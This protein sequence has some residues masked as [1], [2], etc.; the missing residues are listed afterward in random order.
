MRE[1]LLTWIGIGNVEAVLFRGDPAAKP[2]RE[3]ALLRGGIVGSQLPVLRP[4]AVALRPGDILVMAT[5]GIAHKFAARSYDP[6][7]PQ[8]LA[9]QILRDYGKGTDD[10]LVLVV[11]YQGGQP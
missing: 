8:Q 9:D 7:S 1:N 4:T 11:R 5:D 6:T 10:A 2:P 3:S